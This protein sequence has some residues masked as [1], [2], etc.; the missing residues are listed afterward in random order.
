M[1]WR[2]AVGK[3]DGVARVMPPL[4][5][6]CGRENGRVALG[7]H[8]LCMPMAIGREPLPGPPSPYVTS[9]CPDRVLLSAVSIREIWDM[10]LHAGNTGTCEIRAA[11]FKQGGVSSD[12]PREHM[13]LRPTLCSSGHV[14]LAAARPGSGG[15]RRLRR[16]T[17]SP[18]TLDTTCGAHVAHVAVATVTGA[19]NSEG[20]YC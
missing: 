6:T 3:C 17:C 5:L 2:Y 19:V 20:A 15:H 4:L 16:Q 13:V 8:A 14:P 11:L 10:L 7:E 18:T 9:E 1:L 12:L